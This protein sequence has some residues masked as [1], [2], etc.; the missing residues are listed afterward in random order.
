[1]YWFVRVLGGEGSTKN[2]PSSGGAV[3]KRGP[4]CELVSTQACCDCACRKQKVCV[5]Q[6]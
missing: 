3:A 4:C 5:Y 1:M 6:C 2:A